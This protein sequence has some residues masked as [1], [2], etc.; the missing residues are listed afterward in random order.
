MSSGARNEW[1]RLGWRMG[2]KGCGEQA[3]TATLSL[4]LRAAGSGR[5]RGREWQGKGKGVDDVWRGRKRAWGFAVSMSL[6]TARS[7]IVLVTLLVT[8]L[9]TVHCAHASAHVCLSVCP[10]VP[11]SLSTST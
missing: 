8:L 2:V 1:G 9:V 4:V 7:G 6:N 11:M 10:H 5:G 3:H